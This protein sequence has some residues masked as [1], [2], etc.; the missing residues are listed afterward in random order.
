[1]DAL[2]AVLSQLEGFEAPAAAWETEILPARVNEYDPAWLDELSLAGRVAWARLASLR[3]GAERHRSPVRTTPIVLLARR[4]LALWSSLAATL[5]E[6]DASSRAADVADFIRAHGASFFAEIVE[7]TGRLR[8]EVEEALAELTALGRVTCDSFG[9]LRALLLPSEKRRSPGAIR[10]RRRNALFGIEDAGRWALARRKSGG[11]DGAA[12]VEQVART[13]L[14]RYG[15]VFWR[16]MEREAPWLPP[17]RELLRVYRRL[18]A[19]GEVRGGRFVA[20][21]SGEQYALPEAV[22]GLR[23]VRRAERTGDLVSLSAADPLNLAGLV[24]PGARVA[25]LTV[26]RL[27][28]LD[29]VPVAC[30]AAG[31]VRFLERLDGEAQWQ[32]RDALLRRHVPPSLLAMS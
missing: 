9:G 8:T 11:D 10:R 22:S 2:A 18:E 16:L 29:G 31:E 21:V 23:D 17:W 19:R 15:V 26:N 25:S 20:G 12:A 6:P 27:L 32:A 30:L 5:E 1:V 3:P 4:H 13:L 14:K 28:Y 24:T 7:G